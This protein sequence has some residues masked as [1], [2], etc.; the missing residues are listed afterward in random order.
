MQYTAYA[1]SNSLPDHQE[2][3]LETS[4]F[5]DTAIASECAVAFADSL[6]QS[7]HLGATDWVGCIKAIEYKFTLS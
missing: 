5:T 7:E 6:N 4:E 1:T 3:Y 2:P